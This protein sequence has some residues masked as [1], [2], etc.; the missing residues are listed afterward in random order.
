MRCCRR[1][2]PELESIT[3][4]EAKLKWSIDLS[5]Y[6]VAFASLLLRNLLSVPVPV[7]PKPL[8]EQVL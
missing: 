3:N 6:F 7:E 4:V 8:A 5:P 1:E 2:E